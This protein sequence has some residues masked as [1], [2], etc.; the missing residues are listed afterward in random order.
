MA[1]KTLLQIEDLK[2]YFENR[3]GWSTSL[4]NMA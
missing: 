2:M 3:K 4:I 1:E